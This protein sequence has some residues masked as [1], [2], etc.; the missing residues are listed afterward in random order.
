MFSKNW[1]RV[2]IC[3]ALFAIVAQVVHTAS[4][5]F[6]MGWY[7]DPAYFGLWSKLMMPAAGPPGAEFFIASFLANFAIGAIYSGAYAMLGK[8]LPGKG[9]MKG[10]KYGGL[11]FMLAVVPFVLTS[12]VLLA[13][14]TA[15]LLDWAVSDLL[16]L[17]LLGAAL[18]RIIGD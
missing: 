5:V 8:A 7:T 3:G 11:L 9:A 18:T 14:P 12:Y 15:L 1:A 17:L 2:L 4:A 10:L 16:N 6:T 13:I